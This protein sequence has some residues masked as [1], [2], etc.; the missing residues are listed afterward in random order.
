MSSTLHSACMHAQLQV[1]AG[2]LAKPIGKS[3]AS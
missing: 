3:I 1:Y 2:G